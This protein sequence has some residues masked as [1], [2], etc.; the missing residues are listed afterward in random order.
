M[1]EYNVFAFSISFVADKNINILFEIQ[2]KS[3]MHFKIR[4]NDVKSFSLHC[5]L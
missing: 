4:G 3:S 2:K 5:S 1:E